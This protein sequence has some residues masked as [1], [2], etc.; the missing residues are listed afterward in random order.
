MEF[1]SLIRVEYMHIFPDIVHVGSHRL[2]V[3]IHFQEVLDVFVALVNIA[4]LWQ[5][6]LPCLYPQFPPECKPLKII[7]ITWF[8]LG[9]SKGFDMPI[10]KY[11]LC[12]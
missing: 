4:Q 10:F 1:R 3:W 8:Q 12:P 11:T 7:R 5:H 6:L 9:L 2:P